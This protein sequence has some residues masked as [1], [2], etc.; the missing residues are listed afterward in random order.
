MAEAWILTRRWPGVRVGLGTVV[1]VRVGAEVG[2]PFVRR[3]VFMVAI[4]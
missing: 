1:S 3:R 4:L 2:L